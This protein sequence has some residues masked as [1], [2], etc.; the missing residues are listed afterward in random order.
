M[1]TL[2]F[3]LLLLL[4]MNTYAQDQESIYNSNA[5]AARDLS[6]AIQKAAEQNKHVLIQVG[7]N[8]CPWCHRLHHFFHDNTRIDSILKSDYVVLLINY[9]KENKNPEVLAELGYPQRFG[10]PVLVVLNEK[11]ERL[12]TQDTGFLELVK[13]YDA[14]KVE[15]FLLSWNRKA[16]NPETYR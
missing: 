3:I 2:P 5:D 4:A 14:E 11:G 12:H 16:V 15:R 6:Q 7:G 1:R 8:W 13:G 10:F 9:S